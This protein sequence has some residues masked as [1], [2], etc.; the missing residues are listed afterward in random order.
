M[1][2]WNWIPICLPKFDEERWVGVLSG[3]I[4]AGEGEGGEE[5]AEG[6]GEKG[7]GKEAQDEEEEEGDGRRGRIGLVIVTRDRDGFEKVRSWAMD[8]AKVRLLFFLFLQQ[9]P[10]S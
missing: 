8:I 1:G 4:G 2:M 5:G 9:R 7:K 6:N 3:G 10:P